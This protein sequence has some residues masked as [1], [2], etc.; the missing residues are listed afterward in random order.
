L[1]LRLGELEE[2]EEDLVRCHRHDRE[3]SYQW[4][5]KYELLLANYENLK[6]GQRKGM[7]PTVEDDTEE[8]EE[9]GC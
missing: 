1:S 5:I 7:Q 6:L 4:K 9:S 3:W 2:G 8:E